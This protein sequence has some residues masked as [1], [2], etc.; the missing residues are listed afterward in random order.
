MTYATTLEEVLALRSENARLR[1]QLA[2]A[3]DACL[4]L[5]GNHSFATGHGDTV[6]D[7]I[8]EIDGQIARCA[9]QLASETE[10][11]SQWFDECAKQAGKAFKLSQQL[12]RKNTM[13]P[14]VTDNDRDEITVSLDGRELRGWSYANDNERWQK[15][16]QAREYVEGWHDGRG[17]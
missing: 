10:R 4:K 13:N 8:G 11:A 16:L 17:A 12:D 2:N 6:A 7:I 1:V 14:R 5:C 15:M 9:G 3:H